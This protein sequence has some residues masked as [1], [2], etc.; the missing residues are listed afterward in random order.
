[1]GGLLSFLIARIHIPGVIWYFDPHGKLT[2]GSFFLPW[3][4]DP[5][6]GKLT[7]PVW[8][9]DPPLDINPPQML[10]KKSSI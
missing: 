9:Y 1:M 6:H 5:P 10:D 7:P 8:Y 2:P 3:K 4:S